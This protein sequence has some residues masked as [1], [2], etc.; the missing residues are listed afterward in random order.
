MTDTT[1]TITEEQYQQAKLVVQQMEKQKADA[2]AVKRDAVYAKLKPVV[3]S[4]EFALVH[5]QLVQAMA[6]NEDEQVLG[7]H[8][9]ALISIMPNL[10][11]NMNNVAVLIANA[12]QAAQVAAAAQAASTP[13]TEGSANG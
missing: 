3:E 2:L 7:L 9:N 8:A 13:A 10:V 6:G 4:D 11:N 1:T 5:Q 12:E